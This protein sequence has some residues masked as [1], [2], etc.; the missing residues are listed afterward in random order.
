VS[1]TL[2]NKNNRTLNSVP[3][4]A[5]LFEKNASTKLQRTQTQT[6][7]NKRLHKPPEDDEQGKPLPSSLLEEKQK[8]K[9]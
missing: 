3:K 2:K 5:F 4:I 1:Y 6:Q 7:K 9:I 8:R